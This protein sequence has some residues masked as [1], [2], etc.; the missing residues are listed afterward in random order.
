MELTKKEMRLS[1]T[2]L[3]KLKEGWDGVNEGLLKIWIY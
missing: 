1:I 3:N 2:A